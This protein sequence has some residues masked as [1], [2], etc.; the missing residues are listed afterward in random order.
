MCC[1][2]CQELCYQGFS[3]G[4]VANLLRNHLIKGPRS[5]SILQ[6]SSPP[7]PIAT[8]LTCFSSSSHLPP[9]LNVCLLSVCRGPGYVFRAKLFS[10]AQMN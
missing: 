10:I 1:S 6:S 7:C 2:F 8:T 4:P 9:S 3:Q 5:Q